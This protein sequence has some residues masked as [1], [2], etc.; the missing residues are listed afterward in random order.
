MKYLFVCTTFFDMGGFAMARGAVN[1]I[2][3]HDPEARFGALLRPHGRGDQ[4]GFKV[5]D[6]Q[7]GEGFEAFEWAD[8]V[9]DVG[10]ITVQDLYREW[11]MAE[12][13]KTETPYVFMSQ[14]FVKAEPR[15]L[16][17]ALYVARGE[18]SARA[19]KKATGRQPAMVAPDMSFLIRPVAKQVPVRHVFT[20]HLNKPWQPMQPLCDRARDVQLIWKPRDAQGKV[21]E[22][23]LPLTGVSG[24]PEH[25]F[26][27]V[28]Q[29]EHVHTA[30]YQAA[31]AAILQGIPYTAYVP[32]SEKYKDLKAM[33]R[34]DPEALKAQADQVC[35]R[36][37]AVTQ[38]AHGA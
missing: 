19:Y 18:R 21:W 31:C 6:F 33:A 38:K 24:L 22:P 23:P 14:S 26:G 2:T 11:L 12:A 7:A 16:A 29:A 17:H 20:T 8:A 10:G 15:F 13:V 1:G 36:V 25:L 3:A 34:K 4:E 37:V 30:R 9:L 28:G 35:E 5:F 27:V 32:G